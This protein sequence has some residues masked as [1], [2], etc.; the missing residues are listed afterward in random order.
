MLAI[1]TT[2]PERLDNNSVEEIRKWANRLLVSYF[3]E[4]RMFL[5]LNVLFHKGLY[6]R[7]FKNNA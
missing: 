3:N 7:Q 1:N 2:E 6:A 4:Q 5:L